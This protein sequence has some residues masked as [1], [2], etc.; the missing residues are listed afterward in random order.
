MSR[1]PAMSLLGWVTLLLDSVVF[2]WSRAV[3]VSKFSVLLVYLFA[4]SSA[5]ESRALLCS[6]SLT[7]CHFPTHCSSLSFQDK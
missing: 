4:G 6:F 2:G 1:L 3:T 5:R 7:R